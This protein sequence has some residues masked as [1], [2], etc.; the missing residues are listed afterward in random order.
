VATSANWKP[1]EKVIVPAPR[2]MEE[3]EQRLLSK[4]ECADW[5]LCLKS[6]DGVTAPEPKVRELAG[7][8]VA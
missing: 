6:I 2:T 4:Y 7:A 1:G 3:L 5:F 8:G